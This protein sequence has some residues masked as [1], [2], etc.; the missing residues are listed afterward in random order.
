[1]RRRFFLLAFS[2]QGL[3]AQSRPELADRARQALSA[4]RIDQ[5]LLHLSQAIHSPGPD[6]LL[7]ELYNQ[8]GVALSMRGDYVRAG[9]F[10]QRAVVTLQQQ[11]GKDHS[12][13]IPYL[14]NLAEAERKLGRSAGALISYQEASQL[15]KKKHGSSHILYSIVLSNLGRHFLVLGQPLKARPLLEK[16]DRILKGLHSPPEGL[17]L[18]VRGNLCD[19]HFQLGDR[20]QA[21]RICQETLELAGADFATQKA[22]LLLT[23]GQIHRADGQRE[24][25]A[26]HFQK[27]L[28]LLESEPLEMIKAR[29][30]LARLHLKDQEDALAATELGQ[31]LALMLKH[32]FRIGR[33]RA[34]FTHGLADIFDLYMAV[35][36]KQNRLADAFLAANYKKGLSLLESANEKEIFVAAGVVPAERSRWD[37]LEEKIE[38]LRSGKE[39][40]KEALWRLDQERDELYSQLLARY[41]DLEERLLPSVSLKKM[42]QTLRSGELLAQFH[43]PREGVG[44]AFLL[45]RDG[46]RWLP[47]ADHS[48]VQ[49]DLRNLYTIHSAPADDPARLCPCARVGLADGSEW[50]IDLAREDPDLVWKDRQVFIREPAGERLLGEKI[51][52]FDDPEIEDLRLA[53]LK[54]LDKNLLRP[55][56]D[57]PPIHHL[58]V[59]P[60]GWLHFAPLSV[61]GTPPLY[62][63]MAISYTP[64]AAVTALLRSRASPPARLP[65]FAVGDAVYAGDESER[66]D[67]PDTRQEVDTLLR[68]AYG[69]TDGHTLMGSS[70]RR[71][72]FLRLSDSG[73]LARYRFLHLALHGSFEPGRAGSSGL[74]FSLP[75]ALARR[76]PTLG[77]DDRD[78]DGILLGSEA[79]SLKLSADLTVLAACDTVPGLEM[80]GEGM[81]ALPQSLLLAGSRAV[82]A[83]LWSLPGDASI[84]LMRELYPLLFANT[85][86]AQAL[87]QAQEKIAEKKK[88][89]Y[90]WAS[91][92]LYG[93]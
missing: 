38:R 45:T 72:E 61:L 5:A 80:A 89:P 18:A 91:P 12:G 47:L 42:Q 55:L 25:A 23:L 9:E 31:A 54:R 65:F 90:Y 13:K 2:V 62:R 36:L 19:V 83:T 70:A 24:V 35:L 84:D 17:L 92:V 58:I 81:V 10:F 49:S 37:A 87:R 4:G 74:V 40:S 85:P 57:G 56:L 15:I 11:L 16:S 69:K 60:D 77:R 63:R 8:M 43:L 32:R 34:W 1:M 41:P 76:H 68:M 26:E 51:A 86:P 93:H 73:G 14:L 75:G 53:L 52:V 71:G 28:L 7:P 22:V 64:S 39:S 21:T 48:R 79:R 88:D 3:V 6:R 20:P 78:G 46:L 27:A 44:G 82:L 67:L 66:P 33:E 29:A 30:L 59:A 50:W